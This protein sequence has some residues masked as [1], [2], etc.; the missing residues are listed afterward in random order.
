MFHVALVAGITSAIGAGTFVKEKLDVKTNEE[1]LE[2][3]KQVFEAGF[4]IATLGGF[5]TKN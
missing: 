2:S 4:T 1:A 3:C 5:K